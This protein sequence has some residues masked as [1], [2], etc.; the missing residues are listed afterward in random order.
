MGHDHSHGD[1][2]HHGPRNYGRAFLIGISLNVVF[3]IVEKALAGVETQRDE[4]AEQE[5]ILRRQI[6][7]TRA[8][9]LS[10][11]ASWPPHSACQ[12]RGVKHVSTRQPGVRGMPK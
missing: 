10:S 4:L 5:S 7:Q 12:S 3:V 2:H 6:T 9:T 8:G 1:G 11:S